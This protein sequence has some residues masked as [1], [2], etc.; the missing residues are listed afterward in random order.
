MNQQINDWKKECEAFQKWFSNLGGNIANKEQM[1][2]AFIK[3]N[4]KGTSDSNLFNLLE[5]DRINRMSVNKP[6]IL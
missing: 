4:A 3:I 6:E 2:E 1:S 5:S